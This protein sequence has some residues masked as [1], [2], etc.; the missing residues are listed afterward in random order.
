MFVNDNTSITGALHVDDGLVR[1][2]PAAHADL[3]ADLANRFKYKPPTYLRETQALD[4]GL[5]RG[6]PAAHAD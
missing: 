1:G 4:D 5:V 6:T 3:Y 2:T